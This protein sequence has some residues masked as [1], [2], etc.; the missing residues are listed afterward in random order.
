MIDALVNVHGIDTIADA[1]GTTETHYGNPE[2]ADLQSVYSNLT[3]G[4][5]P[6]N[7]CSID[8]F[9]SDLT[10]STNK[11]GSRR[12]VRFT[13]AVAGAHTITAR[14]TAMPSDQSADPDMV[15]H[16]AGPVAQL[17]GAPAPEC[18]PLAPASLCVETGSVSLTPGEYVLEVYEWTNTNSHD[19]ADYPPI[20]RTC[21]NVEVTP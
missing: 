4:G 14:T 13:A 8:S 12:F 11:L 19:D 15:L 1:Y 20:G 10:D 2:N 6:V 3:V 18:T 5:G 9:S 17:D 21:F 16:R 7:V